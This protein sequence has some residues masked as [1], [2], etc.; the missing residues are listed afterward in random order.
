MAQST[1]TIESVWAAKGNLPDNAIVATADGKYPALDGSLITN[2]G[3]GD[4]LAANNLSELTATASVARTNLE[5]GAADAVEFGS[6]ETSQ[7]NFPNLTTAELNAVADAIAGDTYF[8]SDRGQFVRFTGASSY[9]VI[10]SRSYVP[11]LTTTQGAAL[12]LSQTRLFESGVFAASPD[13][14]APTDLLVIYSGKNPASATPTSYLYH[15]GQQGPAGWYN[16]NDVPG[17]VVTAAVFTS[18]TLVRLQLSG[19]KTPTVTGNYIINTTTPAVLSS[20]IL[21]AGSTYEFD[22]SVAYVDL[23]GSNAVL[24]VDYSGLLES[25]GLLSLKNT[26]LALK[27]DLVDISINSPEMPAKMVLNTGSFFAVAGST[28]GLWSASGQVTPSSDGTLTIDLRQSGASVEPLFYS[29]PS[30]SVTLLS[31]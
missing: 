25:S 16:A 6:L 1:T 24:N 18:D 5:L 3:A 10:T 22:F 20:A 21:E 19:V 2:V 26:D 12:T 14:F 8:D 13:V 11:V 31:D 28:F 27:A 7:F 29:T 4:L 17:G 23:L 15:G 9:D 30:S